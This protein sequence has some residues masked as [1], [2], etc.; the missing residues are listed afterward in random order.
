[1]AE[2]VPGGLRPAPGPGGLT[3]PD[4]LT[5]VSTAQRHRHHAT[6]DPPARFP[7]QPQ[8]PVSGRARPPAETTRSPSLCRCPGNDQLSLR[9]GLRLSS[10]ATL[11]PSRRAASV[12][13][14]PALAST[15]RT[16]AGGR[17]GKPGKWR[18]CLDWRERYLPRSSPHLCVG[19]LLQ[20]STMPASEHPALCSHPTGIDVLTENAHE[21]RRNRHATNLIGRTVLETPSRS[22]LYPS[23]R[24]SGDRIPR[25][26]TGR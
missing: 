15:T 23:F 2:P 17:T 7:D 18:C 16:H 10:I 6:H 14:T 24:A 13:G 5:R 11:C 4:S 12:A 19:S 3:S 21:Y 25:T 9:G 8:N 26:R 22:G 1:M 20:G